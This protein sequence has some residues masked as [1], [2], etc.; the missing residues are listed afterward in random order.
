VRVRMRVVQGEAIHAAPGYG[1]LGMG[2]H[3]P[4]GSD[5]GNETLACGAADWLSW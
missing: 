4:V 3:Q 1:S 5:C 2:D